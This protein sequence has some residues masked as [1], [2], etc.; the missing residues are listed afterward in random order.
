MSKLEDVQAKD[1]DN[2]KNKGPVYVDIKGAVKHPNVYKMTS[3]DRVVDLLD[4]AQ[5]LD[6][7][8]VSQINLSEKLTDQK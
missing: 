2:S 5:L 6:D 8:D 3:K 1:G 7:A 4:K